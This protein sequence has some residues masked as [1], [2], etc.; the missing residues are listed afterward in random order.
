M[1]F[2]QWIF[3]ELLIKERID[4]QENH[5]MYFDH[6][7]LIYLQRSCLHDSKDTIIIEPII[8]KD[9][10]KKGK[11]NLN[12]LS[13]KSASVSSSMQFSVVLWYLNSKCSSDPCSLSLLSWC[14]IAFLYGQ[15]FWTPIDIWILADDVQTNWNWK[16]ECK[17]HINIPSTCRVLL[18]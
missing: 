18:H 8:P 14:C 4:I 5:T 6:L 13:D 10:I 3:L 2:N 9:K 12:I 7:N 16:I 1:I 15:F 17:K 11:T